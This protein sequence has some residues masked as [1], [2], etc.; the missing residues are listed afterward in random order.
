MSTKRKVFFT[1]SLLGLF[2]T[3]ALADDKSDCSSRRNS[4]GLAACDRLIASGKFQG[5]R[6][7][8]IYHHRAVFWRS[9]GGDLNKAIADDTEAI[10]LSPKFA[11]AF[12][13]RGLSLWQKG[14]FDRALADGNAAIALDPN[15]GKA[16]NRRGLA[17]RSKGDSY[18]AIKDFDE[19][20]RRVPGIA[21]FHN[22]RGNALRDVGL[23]LKA[24]AD[25]TKAIALDPKD[26]FPYA[27][28]GSIFRQSGE[29]DRAMVDF[30]KA[31]VLNPENGPA[32][33]GRGQT[34]L[35]LGQSDKAQADFKAALKT[36]SPYFSDNKWVHDVARQKL[37][38]IESMPS[39][40][41]SPTMESAKQPALAAITA[42]S[43]RIALVIDNSAYKN[44]PVLPN[45]QRDAALVADTLK[46]TGFAVTLLN[47]LDRET[48]V[49]TLRDFAKQAES[50]DWALV[51][52]AGHGME[53]AGVNYLLPVDAKVAVDRDIGF[54]AVPLD[55]VLNAAERAKMLRLVILD[56]C[57]DNPLS[58]Q[59]RRTMTVASRS[60]SRGLAAVE[61]EP[62][63]L[64]VY[65]AKDGETALDG[66]SKNSP[67][68]MAFVKNVETPGLEVR[69]LF[70]FVRDDVMES[71][72][73]KQK[74]F[75][76]GSI[77]G[78]QDF[79]FVAK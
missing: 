75:S 11:V 12:S 28:R 17:F 8:K 6:L 53:V 33:A 19:A 37:A 77:S 15:D 70:D 25:F 24:E 9:I 41:A 30:N 34:Y 54:E 58:N 10:R 21:L 3:P 16:Y 71:T 72:K 1:L 52:Y 67:F 63:T 68:T 69:R 13:S 46:R 60:V 48:L 2:A 56:A 78:R 38:S 61:P 26:P 51:Y 57:R 45:P 47:D 40:A 50:A 59:M 79:Y 32:L 44:A 31:L 66:E 76:Y 64:V 14:D 23:T 36:R 7:A 39:V 5:E 35:I 62:G 42:G 29:Y 65:A 18:R 20:I 55:Q 74:P 49:R 4:A 43:R 22:N 73:R 27:N